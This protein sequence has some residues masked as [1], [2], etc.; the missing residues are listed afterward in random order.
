MTVEPTPTTDL[1][2]GL[3]I[4]GE[5]VATT[6]T[7]PV[8]DPSR[9]ETVVGWAAAATPEDCEHAVA[10]AQRAFTGWAARSAP[11]RAE[12]VLAALGPLAGSAAARAELL[13]R[14]NGKILGESQIDLAV[15]EGRSRVAAALAE[16]F[17]SLTTLPAPPFDT[18]IHRVATGVV[19]VIVPFNWPLAILG[20]S[21]PYALIAGNTAVV[22][23]PPTAPLAMAETLRVLARGLPPGVLNVVTGRDDAVRP[24]LTDPRVQR[25]VFTGSTAGGRAVMSLASQSLAKVTLELG[26]NDPAILL[27]DVRLDESTAGALAAAAFMTTGQV[28]MAVK[29]VYVPRSRHAELVE[30]MGSALDGQRVGNGLDSGTTMGPMNTARQRDIVGEMLDQ[31]RAKGAEVREYGS[32]DEDAVAAGGHYLRPALVLDPAED[33][34]VVTEEQFGPALPILAY[35]DLDSLVER[36]NSEWSGLC[37]SVWSA[38]L[39]RAAAVAAGLRTGTTWINQANASAC[40]DRAPFGGFRQSGVDREMGP[41]GLL[42]FTETHV[43]TAPAS[44]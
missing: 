14:E 35:D 29:R 37:S 12:L 34:R 15:F 13:T 19:T 40:D 20:A 5:T 30:A 2:T 27:D 32:V 1:V 41:E 43:V 36:L 8:H 4:D 18:R 44:A 25:V 9:P 39:D 11:E 23:P 17:E 3:V 22:K 28:C 38:D 42:D 33:L 21:L 24:L 7:I 16:G 26:G 10:A 6:E 31:A